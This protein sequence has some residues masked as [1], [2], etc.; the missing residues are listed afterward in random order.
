MAGSTD[1]II[2]DQKAGSLLA[3]GLDVARQT[4]LRRDGSI[5]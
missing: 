1:A 2:L 4:I 3:A 5:E